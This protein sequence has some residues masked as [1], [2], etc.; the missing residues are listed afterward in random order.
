MNE[1]TPETRSSNEKEMPFL[2]HLEELRW[3]LLK[4]IAAIVTGAILAYFFSEQILAV[5]IKPY[6]DATLH[7]SNGEAKKLI[8]LNPTG[9]FMLHIKLSIFAGFLVAMPVVFYQIW[10][11]VVPGLLEKERK[12]VPVVVFLSTLCFAAG[13]L[14][15]YLVVLR[16]GLRFLLSFESADLVATLS[17]NEYLEFITMLILVFGIVFEMPILAFILTKI[18]LLT[19]AFMRHYRR[20]GIVTMFVIA[21]VITPTGD[22]INQLLLAGPLI[23]LYEV[24]ILVSKIA[25]KH[26]YE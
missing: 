16:Y 12:Y 24:S 4:S 15:C 22:I 7:L 3:R 26:N 1:V 18:G 20:H 6:H 23:V 21:A 11:F 19:P 10:Q 5:L 25:G 17:V 14:F 13:A 9:G 8:F 2:D